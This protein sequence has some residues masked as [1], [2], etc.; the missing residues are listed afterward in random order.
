LV[1]GRSTSRVRLGVFYME[2]VMYSLLS[3]Y[4]YTEILVLHVSRCRATQA[5]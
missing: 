2:P 4:S 1:Q 3:E 5:R